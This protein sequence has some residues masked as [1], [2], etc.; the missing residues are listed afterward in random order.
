MDQTTPSKRL[1]S[2]EERYAIVTFL[3]IPEN[4]RIM[5]GSAAKDKFV[6]GGQKLTKGHGYQMLAEYVNE[7]IAGATWTPREA[8]S[9]YDS[10]KKA[11]QNAVQ[12]QGANSSDRGLTQK[13]YKKKIFTVQAKIERICPLFEEMDSLFGRRP[14]IRPPI[15]M[16]TSSL[17]DPNYENRSISDDEESTKDNN[18]PSTDGYW[19]END[20]EDPGLGPVRSAF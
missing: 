19:Q 11:Y 2:L 10:F 9:R 6:Q 7:V 8:K 1:T 12:W 4:F 16:Q 17:N 13:D 20:A 5:T 3:R 18:D 14:N 15:L